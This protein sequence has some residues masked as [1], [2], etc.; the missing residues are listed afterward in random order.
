MPKKSK[1]T[2]PPKSHEIPPITVPTPKLR[3]PI[4]PP[5]QQH[6]SRRLEDKLMPSGRRSKYKAK[7]KE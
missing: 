4:A 7:P 5:G 2:T 6:R 1:P 3:V